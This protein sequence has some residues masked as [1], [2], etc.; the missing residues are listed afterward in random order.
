MGLV[1]KIHIIFLQVQILRSN[2]IFGRRIING[3][4]DQNKVLVPNKVISVMF[5]ITGQNYF[6]NF[7]SSLP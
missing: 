1:P 3:M 5:K 6:R 7:L 4:L 2:I